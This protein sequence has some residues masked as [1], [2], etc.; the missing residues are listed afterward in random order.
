MQPRDGE[1]G[2]RNRDE[3]TDDPERAFGVTPG[4]QDE[5]VARAQIEQVDRVAASQRIAQRGAKAQSCNL[6]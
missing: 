2:E 5:A 6:V 4:G 3:H 1:D